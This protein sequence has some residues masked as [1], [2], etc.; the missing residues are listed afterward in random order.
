MSEGDTVEATR[1]A[2]E[3][4]G[5]DAPLAAAIQARL[6]SYRLDELEELLAPR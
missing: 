1:L 2:A 4:G 5:R 3:I 6:K